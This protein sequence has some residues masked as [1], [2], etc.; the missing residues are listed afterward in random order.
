MV[1]NSFVILQVDYCNSILAGLSKYQSILNV[2]ATLIFGRGRH[3]QV[4][5]LLRDRQAQLPIEFKCSLLIYKALNGLAQTT[6]P[7]IVSTYLRGVALGSSQD[8]CVLSPLI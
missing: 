2:A 5:P 7:I 8:V 1:I 4:K 6:Y 3:D